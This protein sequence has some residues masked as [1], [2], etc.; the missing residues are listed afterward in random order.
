[1]SVRP[2]GKYNL[3]Q[4]FLLT[5]VV[6]TLNCETHAPAAA[7]DKSVDVIFRLFKTSFIEPASIKL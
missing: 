4:E 5:K 1:M 3:M 7:A 2:A 6:E